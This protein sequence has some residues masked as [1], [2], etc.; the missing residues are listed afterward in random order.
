MTNFENAFLQILEAEGQSYVHLPKDKGGPT[1]YGITLATLSAYRGRAASEQEVK[2]LSIDEAKKIYFK[3]YWLPM[4]IEGLPYPLSIALFDQAVNRGIQGATI[5]LQRCLSVT[6]DGIL[7]PITRAMAL[8]RDPKAL[9]WE[10]I[11]E[12]TRAYGRIIQRDP[13]QAVFLVGWLYRLSRL[14]EVLL[15]PELAQKSPFLF[16]AVQSPKDGEPFP[17]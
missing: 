4:H 11:K 2:D 13:G 8:N 3:L 10:F 16:A 9:T 7:G 5:T 14:T 1:H 12:S 6:Q 17:G 15:L